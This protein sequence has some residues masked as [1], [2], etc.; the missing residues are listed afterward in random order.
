MRAVVTA[1]PDEVRKSTLWRGGVDMPGLSTATLHLANYGELLILRVRCGR[2][3]RARESVALTREQARELRDV[4][5]R[6]LDGE[7]P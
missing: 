2:V 7:G 6:W 1:T 3:D 5:D 4:L